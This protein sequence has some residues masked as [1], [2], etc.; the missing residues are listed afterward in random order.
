[1]LVVNHLLKC[2]GTA[3]IIFDE[4]QKVIPGA[5]DV[6]MPGLRE[7][8]ALTYMKEDKKRR[9]HHEISTSN[10]IFLFISDI[11]AND[12]ETLLMYH[13]DRN[14]I[15]IS[16]QRST[17][18]VAADKQWNTLNFGKLIKE[19]IPFLP[20]EKEQIIDVLRSKLREIALNF[21]SKLDKNNNY[22]KDFFVHDSVLEYLGSNEFIDY[23][24]VAQSFNVTQRSV[25][26]NT[27]INDKF[28]ETGIISRNKTF[29]VLG[30]RG[31]DNAGLKTYEFKLLQM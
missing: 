15:P 22:W 27:C 20:M 1:M 8:G 19:V 11:G 16:Q 23:R 29:A 26:G 9:T 24:L 7:G 3:L 6:L 5:L 12:L 2:K 13:Q 28:Y 4:V 17:V 18:K 21:N 30:G 31:L 14:K 10:A 25:G